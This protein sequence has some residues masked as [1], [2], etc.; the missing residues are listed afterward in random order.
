MHIFF[1]KQKKLFS[2]EE[3]S[4]VA[5][6]HDAISALFARA[7][8]VCVCVCVNVEHMFV[9]VISFVYLRCFMVC[10][11]KYRRKILS[12]KKD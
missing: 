3:N 9:D 6:A 12:K 1:W 2:I 4:S 8:D 11:S 5:A 7:R 10:L